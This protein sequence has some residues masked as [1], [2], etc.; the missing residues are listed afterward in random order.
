MDSPPGRPLAIVAGAGSGK[1]LVLLR[2]AVALPPATAAASGP[3]L[4]VL[5]LTFS[6]AAAA[7]VRTRI[8]I[9]ATVPFAGSGALGATGAAAAAAAG[10]H[11]TTFHAL[12]LTVLRSATDAE[13]E[14]LGRRRG[15]SLYA[16]RQQ[17]LVVGE[18]LMAGQVGRG[19]G[20]AAII[21]A[22]HKRIQSA[23]VL[24][25]A[26]SLQQSLVLSDGNGERVHGDKEVGGR[27]GAG[28]SG[29]GGGDGAD[30][31]IGAGTGSGSGSLRGSGNRGTG[32]SAGGGVGRGSMGGTVG[33]S[34]RGAGPGSRANGTS[35]SGRDAP[36]MPPLFVSDA[37]A[38]QTDT[39]ITGVGD[40]YE[41]RMSRYN[42]VDFGDL[43]GLAVAV[44][45]GCG[46]LRR[47]WRR[48]FRH[49]LV[50]EGQDVSAANLHLLKLLSGYDPACEEDRRGGDGDGDG[51]V[52]LA[53]PPLSRLGVTFVG[54]DDQA[55]YAFRGS[56]PDAFA[57]FSAHFGRPGA[58]V[59]TCVLGE[60][61]RSTRSIVRACASLI[62]AAGP[63]RLAKELTTRAAR[64]PDVAVARCR[65][66]AVEAGWIHQK[67]VEL[68]AGGDDNSGGVECSAAAGRIPLGDIAVL[69]RT[70][71]LVAE[72]AAKLRERGLD[73]V[74]F[75]P[76]GGSGGGAARGGVAASGR[77]GQVTAQPGGVAADPAAAAPGVGWRRRLL[78]GAPCT[79]LWRC[80]GWRPTPLMMRRLLQSR[81]P[82][83]RGCHRPPWRYYRLWRL[84]QA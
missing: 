33:G 11:V 12:G 52:G 8:G 64:G 15:F 73:V 1:T 29:G 58:P 32:E 69:L 65:N 78:P 17:R 76:A 16:T 45:A 13:L 75:S 46:P 28:S 7:E 84:R 14:P 53:L 77:G 36:D 37:F 83:R 44:L 66:A 21:A 50:D 4:P 42:A 2:R 26:V 40:A 3:P 51:E 72:I 10:A 6:R 31:V 48:R 67:V 47:R 55:I 71:S 30:T 22:V 56:S 74:A 23:K 5:V 35:S 24:A 39:D 80:C 63:G 82:L 43:L 60:N 38:A 61:H 18:A 20:N 19:G 62:E 49:I 57:H 79:P 27:A 41:A 81:A 70:R 34:G 25:S 59:T 9:M 68:T 54:C